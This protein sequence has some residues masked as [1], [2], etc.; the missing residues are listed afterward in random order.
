VAWAYGEV[1]PAALQNAVI[2]DI[3]LAPRN[4]AGMVACG[5][6]LERLKFADIAHANAALFVEVVNRG[7]KL[8]L[9]V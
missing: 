5:T 9:G 1:D 2:Q 6:D 4:A 7:N 3:W 8:A